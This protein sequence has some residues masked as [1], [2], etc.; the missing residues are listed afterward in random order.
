[1]LLS[2]CFR[3][4]RVEETLTSYR[5][6]FPFLSVAIQRQSFI[7]NYKHIYIVNDIANKGVFKK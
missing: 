4:S 3:R 2:L 5:M 1:M 7:M 6:N